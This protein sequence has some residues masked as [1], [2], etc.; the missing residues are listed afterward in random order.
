MRCTPARTAEWFTIASPIDT[1]G[2]VTCGVY[3]VIDDVDAH[4]AVATSH[5]AIVIAPPHDNDYGGRGYEVRD[6][7]G[8]FW[9]FGSY[10][11]FA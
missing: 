6:C 5:G 2:V 10:D 8:N 7:E 11:P 9:S 4:C 1:G 3:G